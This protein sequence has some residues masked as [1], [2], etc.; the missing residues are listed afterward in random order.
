[1]QKKTK[2]NEKISEAK[3]I[4]EKYKQGKANLEAR[5]VEE[6]K[7]WRLQMWQGRD[8]E[9]GVTPSSSAYMWN[10]VVNKHADMMDNYPIPALL[11]R[12]ESDKNEAETLT[13]IVP[14]ILER[15][16]FEETY[17]SALWYKLKHG[18]SCFGVF[19][20]PKADGGIGDISISNIDLLRVF[21]DPTVSDIQKSSNLFICA[22]VDTEALKAEYP[23]ADINGERI[24]LT[25]YEKDDNVD[26][27]NQSLVVDWYYKKNVDGKSVLHFCKFTGDTI[28]YSS[29]NDKNYSKRGYYDHG[30]YPVVFDTLYPEED[31]VTGYGV[32]SV[33]K[34]TQSYID[35]LDALLMNYT[36]KATTPRWFKKK[37]VGINEAEF[38]DWSKPFVSVTGDI[39]EERFQQITMSPMSG[40][41]YNLLERKINELKE[42]I[43]NRDV[44]SGGTMAGVTSGAAIATLQEAG[45]KTSRDAIKTSYRAYIKIIRMVVELIRQFY[46][47]ERTFRIVK[48]NEGEKFVSYSNKGITLQDIKGVGGNLIKDSEGMTFKR[49]P[50]FDISVK[51]QKTN[52][53]SKLSQNETASNLYKMGI[54]NP[55]NAEQAS[56]MLS[57]MDFEG[58]DEIVAKI[59]EGQTLLGNIEQLKAEIENLKGF[60]AMLRGGGAGGMG[61][62]NTPHPSAS[63]PP[64]PQGEGFKSG[65]PVA[66]A[67]KGAEKVALNNYGQT[68]AGRAN[69]VKEE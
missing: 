40:I 47:T 64:S 31:Q 57:M 26:R 34:D 59:S 4:L 50:V 6:E 20:D 12:E 58:K 21:W 68:L 18:T 56:I 54:F 62:Q 17:S 14:V 37:D 51:A 5:I 42:T 11:P 33:T 16:D 10:A 66:V 48:P 45:N 43:G 41:Y 25:E 39:T 69:N 35:C 46:T 61:G 60:I 19:W 32:I 53:Y 63:L 28:L 9:T 13:D 23:E 2:V 29:E 7:A 38:S 65:N 15:T 67:T 44:N 30:M 52:P 1:M 8:T 49:K 3:G 36:K 55:D 27:S 22:A 24:T